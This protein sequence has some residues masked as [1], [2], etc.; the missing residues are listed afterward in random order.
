MDQTVRSVVGRVILALL[1]GCSSSNADPPGDDPLA[2]LPY[3]RELLSF[4]PGEG[5]GFGSDKLPD[6]VLGPPRGKG[7]SAGSLDVLSLG[8]GGEIVLGFG[9]R[10][11]VDGPGPDLVVFENAFYA[12]GDASAA[13]AEPGE[14]AVSWDGQEFVAFDCSTE[15][16]E[17]GDYPGCAGTAPTLEYDPQEIDPIVP[18]LTGGN[19]FDLEA[20]GISEAR[21]VRIRDRSGEGSAPTAGFDLDAIGLV[22]STARDE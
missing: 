10:A 15:G 9:A 22:H 7:E 3:A 1:V 11:M 6:I 4:T 17:P 14:V 20:L 19:A 2:R 21:Y 13:F 18:E 5:A 16:G 8:S 12:G